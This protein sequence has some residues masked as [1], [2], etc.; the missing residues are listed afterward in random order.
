MTLPQNKGLHVI[1]Y[2]AQCLKRT[3]SLTYMSLLCVT[4]QLVCRH[5]VNSSPF[6]SP[7]LSSSLCSQYTAKI[8]AMLSQRRHKQAQDQSRVLQQAQAK[9]ISQEEETSH[10]S[11]GNVCERAEAEYPAG[12]ASFAGAAKGQCHP[13]IGYVRRV[14]HD[15]IADPVG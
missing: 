14:T 10:C 7:G 8:R 6:V 1:H 11:Q 9:F 15:E 2:F 5:R 4:A 12:L 3:A 13:C